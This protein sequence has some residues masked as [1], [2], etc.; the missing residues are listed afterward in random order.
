MNTTALENMICV[1]EQKTDIMA[2]KMICEQ[3]VFCLFPSPKI[4]FTNAPRD[5]EL[6]FD[7]QIYDEITEHLSSYAQRALVFDDNGRAIAILPTL[8]PSSSLGVALRFD[9]S[10]GELLRLASACDF[11]HLFCVSKSTQINSVRLSA[12]LGGMMDEFSAFFKELSNCFFSF[13]NFLL[14][15]SPK[16]K[17][18][19]I[20]RICLDTSHF[21]G[22]PISLSVPEAH[23]CEDAL[24]QT[25]LPLLI[26]FLVSLLMLTRSNAE[27]RSAR[28]SLVPTRSSVIM[29]VSIKAD[30]SVCADVGLL[31]WKHIAYDKNMLFDVWA[32]GE[33]VTVRFDPCRAEWSLLGLKQY[34]G[35]DIIEEE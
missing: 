19:K 1:Q 30:R 9:I 3:Y 22:C 33:Y 24:E 18:E 34:F 35:T 13:D 17:F 20:E 7:T 5:A 21:M 6:L 26:A 11:L 12:R 4:L 16:E 25:D 8:Y 14:C 2:R 31:K 23:L 15:L 28:I 29:S 10:V 27:D 32:D